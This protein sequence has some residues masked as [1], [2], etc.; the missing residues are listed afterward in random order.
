MDSLEYL[1]SRSHSQ[2]P[3]ENIHTIIVM[4]E[5]ERYLNTAK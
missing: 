5:S 2:I 4:V 1:E 3:P